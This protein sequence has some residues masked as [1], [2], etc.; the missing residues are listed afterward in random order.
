M[1]NY[2]SGEDFFESENFCRGWRKVA[3]LR[4]SISNPVTR[5]V[6]L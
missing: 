4:N 3:V 2:M 1:L 6:M 5:D